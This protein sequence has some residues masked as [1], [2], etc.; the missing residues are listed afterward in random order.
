MVQP[1]GPAGL[2]TPALSWGRGYTRA[3]YPADV[4][5]GAA[6]TYTV[7]NDSYERIMSAFGT[8]TTSATVASRVPRLEYHDADGN[9]MAAITAANTVAASSQVDITWLLGM[10]YSNANE[11][12]DMCFGLPDLIL[13]YKWSTV[14]TLLNMDP[15][16]TITGFR[17]I[18]ETFWTGFRGVPVGAVPLDETDG[19][20]GGG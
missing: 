14:F 9:V 1:S 8:V 4:A 12:F 19:L 13:P 15:A 6:A 2:I 18:S 7:R 17:V 5:A 3:H 20:Y 11:S 16:D 10:G